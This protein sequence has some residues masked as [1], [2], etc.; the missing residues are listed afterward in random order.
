MKMLQDRVKLR[1]AQ[2]APNKDAAHPFDIEHGTDTGGYLSPAEILTGHAHDAMQYG[3]S[4]IAP[5]VF[6]QVIARWSATLGE[7]SRKSSGAK[8][9]EVFGAD[10]AAKA[11]THNEAEGHTGGAACARQSANRRSDA[12]DSNSRI[13][14]YSF[15]DIG[16]GK[17][18]ALLLASQ[19]S[20][21][22]TANQFPGPLAAGASLRSAIGVELSAELAGIAQRNIEIW[23]RAGKARCKIHVLNQDALKFCWPRTSLL[24]FMYN[25]FACEMVEQLLERL[26]RAAERL[27]GTAIPGCAPV[28][29]R[30]QQK[31]TGKNAGATEDASAGITIDLLYANPTCADVVSKRGKW[32]LR[33]TDRID[34]DAAD[35]AADPYGTTF[36]RVSCYRLRH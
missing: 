10:V 34:M 4:A 16:A 5:S 8:A 6:R 17:G 11:A 7:S 21:S 9:P 32:V 35:I 1:S 2:I 3:Y 31:R 30:Q 24:V 25:P 15:V 19:F 23:K 22:L 36:D 29:E 28:R 20:A 18:R 27:S 13:S 26:E 12:N 14:E 33:W